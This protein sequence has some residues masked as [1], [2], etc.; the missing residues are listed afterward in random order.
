M[1]DHYFALGAIGFIWLTFLF[2]NI[3]LLFGIL[4]IVAPHFQFIPN[5]GLPESERTT[6]FAEIF[7]GKDEEQWP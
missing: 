5:V 3:I 1:V 7:C 2:M 4:A 6:A